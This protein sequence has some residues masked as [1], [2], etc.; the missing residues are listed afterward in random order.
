MAGGQTKTGIGRLLIGRSQVATGRMRFSSNLH[1]PKA[2]ARFANIR[3][4]WMGHARIIG[5][6]TNVAQVETYIGQ[7]VSPAV[8]GPVGSASAQGVSATYTD[9]VTVG[10]AAAPIITADCDVFD[11]SIAISAITGT[12]IENTSPKVA[13]LQLKRVEP[14]HAT[15]ANQ[16][17]NII[18]ELPVRVGL[19]TSG[20]LLLPS[21]YHE[22]VG[23]GYIPIDL[24]AMAI[25]TIKLEDWVESITFSWT[26]QGRL[27]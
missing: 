21:Y 9:D 22:T 24:G 8:A 27:S 15:A 6:N 26:M 19:D 2:R 5:R 20:N 25:V 10:T 11:F 1:K 12:P 3:T 7:V 14:D 23:K 18:L 16:T 13:T 4:Q 17:V